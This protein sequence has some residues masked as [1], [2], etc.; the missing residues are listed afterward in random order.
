MT[1][2]GTFEAPGNTVSVI[3]TA[4]NTVLTTITVGRAPN[5]VAITPNG[6]RVYVANQRDDN[7]SVIDTAINTV[8]DTVSVGDRPLSVAIT[9][10]GTRAYVT[11]AGD[12]TVS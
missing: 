3:D 1:N 11:N 12:D 5:G 6:T 9:P 8:I 2:S 4:T 7:V 10:D